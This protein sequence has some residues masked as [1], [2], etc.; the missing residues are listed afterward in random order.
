MNQLKK[1]KAPHPDFLLRLS[2]RRVGIEPTTF[3]LE[4]RCSIQLS[5]PPKPVNNIIIFRQF[6]NLKNLL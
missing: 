2:M 5:Y 3:G 4:D 1:K 6:V